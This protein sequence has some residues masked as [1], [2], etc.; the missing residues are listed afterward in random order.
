MVVL[1][2]ATSA[3]GVGLE[4]LLLFRAMGAFRGLVTVGAFKEISFYLA[5]IVGAF[6]GAAFY[7]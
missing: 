3:G 5:G 1:F 4:M 2:L 6:S 7:Y